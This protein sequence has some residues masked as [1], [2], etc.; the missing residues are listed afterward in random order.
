MAD[1]GVRYED[2]QDKNNEGSDDPV[3]RDLYARLLSDTPAETST[4]NQVRE[5]VENME[6]ERMAHQALHQLNVKR[7][8]ELGETRE[9]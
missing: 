2:E 8:R 3:L 6:D 7:A 1:G 5:W 9:N 4:G